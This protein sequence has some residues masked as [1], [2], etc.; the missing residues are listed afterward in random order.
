MPCTY[1][2]SGESN[3]RL[4][5]EIDTKT[6]HLCE[7]CKVLEENDLI[8]SLSKSIQVWWKG[9]KEW[10]HKRLV[11]EAREREKHALAITARNKLT[12]AERKALGVK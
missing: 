2:T 1:E 4:S 8:K 6:A 7:T 5:R 9:H 11:R 10:D 3:T 12:V